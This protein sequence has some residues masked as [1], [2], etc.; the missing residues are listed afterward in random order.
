[1]PITTIDQDNPY[2]KKYGGLKVSEEL[3]SH[4]REMQQN[5]AMM[6]M[7][8]FNDVQLPNAGDELLPFLSE[9]TFAG[10]A[11]QA[12]DIGSMNGI[13]QQD[14]TGLMNEVNSRTSA[15]SDF[16]HFL[17]GVYSGGIEHNPLLGVAV[18]TA[19]AGA[20]GAGAAGGGGGSAGADA[21]TGVSLPASATMLPAPMAGMIPAAS[22][23]VLAATG[24]P[25]S[26]AGPAMAA[27]GAAAGGAA[28]GG[29]SSIGNLL[30][31]INSG[32]GIATGVNNLVGNDTNVQ[33]PAPT[34]SGAT[35]SMGPLADFMTDYAKPQAS[36]AVNPV[37]TSALPQMK[38]S[39]MSAP[40]TSLEPIDMNSLPKKL[41][42]KEKENQIGDLLASIPEALAVAGDL[43]GVMNHNKVQYPAPGQ[44]GGAMNPYAAAFGGLPRPASLGDILNSLPRMR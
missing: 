3:A 22:P 5:G 37:D 27:G 25:M 42:S 41:K 2:L 32:L 16:R 20:V 14:L 21:L 30:R 43:L 6:G 24:P 19:L 29:G 4:L 7:N 9:L 26:L 8:P 40:T 35:G 11:Q 18:G 28:M 1:M 17:R 10:Q 34:G 36:S 12:A 33:T 38:A 39:P 23:A 13:P 31:N 15:D 44:G